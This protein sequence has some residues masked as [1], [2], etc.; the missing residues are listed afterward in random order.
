MMFERL[1]A[2]AERTAERRVSERIEAMAERIAADRPPGIAA[3]AGEDG[4]RLS[5]RRLR[6]RFALD[7]GL[8]WLRLDGG[9]Q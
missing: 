2:R 1:M 6:G 3:D 9:G 8:R 4:V 5:G 7:P